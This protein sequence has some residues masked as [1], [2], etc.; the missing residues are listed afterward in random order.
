MPSPFPGMDPYI[1]GQLWPGFHTQFIS[2]LQ[3]TLSP[4]LRPRYRILI[5]E[6]VYLSREPEGERGMIRPDGSVFESL[7]GDTLLW[8][9]SGAGVATL[10]PPVTVPLPQ[11]EAE[12]QVYLEV[13]RS[14]TGRLACVIEL[15]SP[16]NKESGSGRQEY[17]NKRAAVL[18]STAHLIELDL[19]RRGVR[20]PTAQP[21]PQADYYAFVSRVSERPLCGVWPIGLR[22][23]LPPVPIPLLDGDPDVQLDLQAVFDAVYDGAEYSY[24]LNYSKEPEP[25]V[26]PVD[27]EWVRELVREASG[28]PA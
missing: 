15:L 28:R 2:Q 24:L 12:R 13:R 4:L 19:L 27:L 25:P 5:E 8:Q 14:E 10:K 7:I 11:Q 26:S 22:E 23:S 16:V 3:R 17:L 20:L 1:E 9:P 21:V 6:H 18:W